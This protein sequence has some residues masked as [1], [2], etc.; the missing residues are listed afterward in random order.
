MAYTPTTGFA[1]N[2]TVTDTS[3]SNITFPVVR[4]SLQNPATILTYT[5]SLCGNHPVR[6][7]TFTDFRVTIEIDYDQA[8]QP[9]QT[10]VGIIPS[11][12]LTNVNLVVSNAS[13]DG[14][15]ITSMIVSDMPHTVE[16]AGKV[17]L[18]INAQISGGTV[19]PPNGTAY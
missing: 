6:A 10:S 9:F 2:V 1:G 3:A 18:S 17:M 19:T 11:T 16:R 12:Q 15:T 7:A 4:W 13:N 14:W 8:H 5:N